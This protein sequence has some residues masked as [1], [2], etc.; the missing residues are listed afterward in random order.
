MKYL[1]ELRR[2]FIARQSRPYYL[3]HY[4]GKTV[5]VQSIYRLLNDTYEDH[6]LLHRDDEQK[7][8]YNLVI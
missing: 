8:L 1:V 6:T 4:R 2:M 5:S 3:F 7:Q